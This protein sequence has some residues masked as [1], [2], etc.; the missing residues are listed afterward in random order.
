MTKLLWKIFLSIKLFFS[1][2][3]L[4]DTNV[5]KQPIDFKVNRLDV[6]CCGWGDRIRAILKHTVPGEKLLI[7]MGPCS[8]ITQN[9]FSYLFP[10]FDILEVKTSKTC[11]T[12]VP[13][14]P[15]ANILVSSNSSTGY[16]KCIG[17]K[18]DN[19]EINVFGNHTK[20]FDILINKIN[21]RVI[22][23][24]YNNVR[25]EIQKYADNFLNKH[26]K[27]VSWHVR[28]GNN[29]GKRGDVDFIRKGRGKLF[30]DN[31]DLYLNKTV[32]KIINLAKRYTRTTNFKIAVF[33]DTKMIHD[34]IIKFSDRFIGRDDILFAKSGHFFTY[35]KLKLNNAG[36]KCNIKWFTD[37]VTD[38]LIMGKSDM[39][40]S[41]NPSGFTIMPSIKL[42]E[43]NKYICLF[44]NKKFNCF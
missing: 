18:N 37:P 1:L 23:E 6:I 28:F 2:D 34:K 3:P 12:I 36:S 38:M 30:G 29:Y 42:L 25:P 10:G 8:G 27:V 13:F 33:T 9:V 14:E 43:R 21:Q 19:S 39:L 32:P 16:G 7:N 24:L 5:I 15:N 4:I 26:A 41:S 40:I 22:N 35:T 44:K 20:L 31:I 11:E 17:F